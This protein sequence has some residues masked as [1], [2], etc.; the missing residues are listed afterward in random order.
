MVEV[1]ALSGQDSSKDNG[2]I[3][4]T[5]PLCIARLCSAKE[6]SVEGSLGSLKNVPQIAGFL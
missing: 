5:F 3:P 2:G 4:L 1:E 6:G